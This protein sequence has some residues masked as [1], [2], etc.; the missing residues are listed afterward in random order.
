MPTSDQTKR[1]FLTP[2]HRICRVNYIPRTLGFA[3]IFVSLVLISHE[4]EISP[5]HF[6]ISVL[7][8]LIYP[9][10][11]YLHGW[12]TRDSK[13]TERRYLLLDCI[14][15]G[16][17]VG[18][19]GF[20]LWIT[21]TL[22]AATLLNNAVNGGLPRLALG[23]VLFL[24]ASIAGF[25]AFA[26]TFIP[27]A[28]LRVDL[29]VMITSLMYIL[30]LGL[31]FFW[32]NQQLAQA[33]K[34]IAHKNRIFQSLLKL[35]MLI[36]ESVDL[37]SLA[38]Q[39]LSQLQALHPRE[40]FGVVRFSR[41]RPKLIEQTAF[42]GLSDEQERAFLKSL[43]E[44]HASQSDP[45]IIALSHDG[46]EIKALPL[47]R[48]LSRGDTYLLLSTPEEDFNQEEIQLFMD[49]L[50]SALENKLL[51][52][53]LRRA[54]ETDGLTGL[55]NRGYLE[56]NLE[57]LIREK[58]K[59]PEIDFAIILIDLIGLKQANDEHGHETGDA[60]IRHVAQGLMA[61]ARE[62]DMVARYGGDEFVILCRNCS[63][64]G[65]EQAVA[66]LRQH[67]EGKSCPIQTASQRTLEI[68][69]DLSIGV[70]GSDQQPAS[71]V[72]RVADQRMYQNKE[73]YYQKNKR[74]R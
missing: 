72:L 43:R 32:Q 55:Y 65:A 62:T 61:V 63:E 48:H 3:A 44:K 23:S 10:L 13:E 53:E 67:I 9:H 29:F 47:D 46:F 27:S 25:A 57:Q 2:P 68:P 11:V 70:A 17:W 54:A 66:R 21:F 33:H 36:N 41:A 37:Q 69:V 58:Q 28:S 20:H 38:R 40:A 30:G 18:A 42:L 34:D 5:L 12:L 73:A 74:Y 51:T 35:G 15:V 14:L 52:E 59:Y 7:I 1:A 19:L 4:R 8:F 50:A 31:T 6:S 71:E 16:G 22:L 56:E 24:G 26:P 64:A 49:Q 60:L 39:A 45:T